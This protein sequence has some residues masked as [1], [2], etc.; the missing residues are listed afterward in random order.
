MTDTS[1]E[2]VGLSVEALRKIAGD[3]R[4]HAHDDW[5]DSDC[6]S[7]AAD[8]LETVAFENSALRAQ[9]QAARDKV[10]SLL[11]RVDDALAPEDGGV[12]MHAMGQTPDWFIEAAAF[13]CN[14]TPSPPALRGRVM[15]EKT[16][17]NCA[18]YGE[19]GAGEPGFC[20]WAKSM[21][22]VMQHILSAMTAEPSGMINYSSF[23]GKAVPTDPDHCCASH[24]E[25]PDG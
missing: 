23:D 20:L 1:K 8:R 19:N 21:P 25:D 17:Q 5:D 10:A 7:R 11:K 6:I 22:P 9:L 3:Q 2:A 16:C 4:N 18:H 24:K 12:S 15:A 14:V 13:A